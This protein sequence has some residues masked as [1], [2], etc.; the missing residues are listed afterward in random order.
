MATEVIMPQ[1]GFDMQEG[2]VVRWVK[3]EGDAVDRGEVVA[4][5]ETDKAVVELEAFASGVLR[6]IVVAEGTRVPVGQVIAVIATPGEELP[7]LPPATAPPSPQSPVPSPEPPPS[8][9]LQGDVPSPPPSPSP[10]PFTLPPSPS[11]SPS[12]VRASPLARRLAEEMRID[13]ARLQGTGPGGRITRDDVLAAA[14]SPAAPRPSLVPSPESP[15]P[16]PSDQ[17]PETRDPAL[18]PMRQAIGRRMAQAKREIPH[19][20]VSMDVDMGAAMALREQINAQLTTY[21]PSPSPSPA[22]STLHP[23]P[24]QDR[25]SVNDLLLKAC[26]MALT[27]HPQINA[28]WIEDRFQPNAGVTIGLAVAL[29]EGLIAP[30]IPDADH[31]TLVELARASRDLVERARGGV[32]KPQ[33]YA[34]VTFSVSN[35]GMYGVDS[36]IAIVTPPQAAVL[37]VGRVLPRPVVRDGQIA[38]AQMMNMTVAADHRITD[39]AQVALFMGEVR[40]LLEHP[41]RL[42]L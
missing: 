33:E 18:S 30:G 4:E 2:T 13:L 22:P 32:L 36:F 41:L 25:V 15:V 27:H 10:S 17:R 35:L 31:K 28:A 7:D 21:V 8:P 24:S 14:P 11:P 12:R 16:H 9:P 29:D 37:S 3:Q 34:G 5:I 42:L 40:D 20:Y 38:V 26:A 39:G 19:F 23:A 1:M 6:R